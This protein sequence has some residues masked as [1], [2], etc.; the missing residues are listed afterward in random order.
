MIFIIILILLLLIIF[1]LSIKNTNIVL[2][3]K[4]KKKKIRKKKK[5]KKGKKT[6]SSSGGPNFNTFTIDDGGASAILLNIQKM[7]KELEEKR[8]ALEDASDL[9]FKQLENDN[10]LKEIGA[11]NILFY[12][13]IIKEINDRTKK[14]EED[15]LNAEQININ[16]NM[17][18]KN[19]QEEKKK[20]EAYLKKLEEDQIPK[21][22]K[23]NEYIK[24]W[25][26]I[27]NF[28]VNIRNNI[29]KKNDIISYCENDNCEQKSEN[30]CIDPCK[31]KNKPAPAEEWGFR[32]NKFDKCYSKNRFKK[33]E[34]HVNEKSIFKSKF[35]DFKFKILKFEIEIDNINKD[36]KYQYHVLQ[37]E[38]NNNNYY[39]LFSIGSKLNFEKCDKKENILMSKIDLIINNLIESI[40][41]N[42][43]I[44]F[45]F[46]GHSMGSSIIIHIAY[47]LKT[48]HIDIFNNNCIF[49]G[50]G[51]VR[52]LPIKIADELKSPNIFM[53]L[54]AEINS[55]QDIY[56]DIR[57][58]MGA[59]IIDKRFGDNNL[60][61]DFFLQLSNLL[62]YK[63]QLIDGDGNAINY[64]SNMVSFPYKYKLYE[65]FY[66]ALYD[67]IRNNTKII[68]WETFKTSEN[69]NKI[70]IIESY[71][72]SEYLHK[73]EKYQIPLNAAFIN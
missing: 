43:N 23:D 31:K 40:K 62:N 63:N 67:N 21:I 45:I 3:G 4:K 9:R 56:I 53:F 6:K 7:Q 71:D 57:Y 27:Y 46:C 30:D 10:K 58:L 52:Y 16:A 19:I 73:W 20:I 65:P 33:I 17:K 26:S 64:M 32:T 29:N 25:L 61:N 55:Q 24:E 13:N 38:Q 28:C 37:S 70:N 18:L 1:I 39:Y 51:F 44:K 34:D 35:N 47:K 60:P 49:I 11:N 15:Y 42:T 36:I 22:L 66:I 68:E 50:S 14:I 54:Y 69:F 48:E 8:K 59:D 72:K 2:G 41:T 5:K 12:E